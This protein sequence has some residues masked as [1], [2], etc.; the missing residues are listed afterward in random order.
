MPSETAHLHT[1]Q[2]H[3]QQ[4]QLQLPSLNFTTALSQSALSPSLRPCGP[5]SLLKVECLVRARIPTTDPSRGQCHL[6]SYINNH[7]ALE[8]LA[9]VYGDIHSKTLNRI[10]V[11]GETDLDRAARG[12]LPLE[13]AEALGF[14]HGRANEN[15]NGNGN[16]GVVH[17]QPRNANAHSALLLALGDPHAAAHAHHANGHAPNRPA[18]ATGLASSNPAA[19]LPVLLLPNGHSTP[20]PPSPLAAAATAIG[21]PS[22][23]AESA[24]LVRI[25]SSCFTGETLGSARCDCA[26]QLQESLRMIA[27]EGRGVVVYLQQEGRGIG[28][29]DKLRAYNLQDLGADTVT[30]NTLLHHPPDARQYTVAAAILAD[31]GSDPVRLLTNNPDKIAQL[32]RDGVRVAGR[33]PM[34][35]LSWKERRKSSGT[36]GRV[37]EVDGYLITKVRKMNHLLDLPWEAESRTATATTTTA[38]TATMAATMATTMATTTTATM[39]TTM[40]TATT[41]TTGGAEHNA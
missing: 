5:S 23:S 13:R 27:S 26:E 28:L 29:R 40:A 2:H 8:H 31:L 30:A 35:P 34:V 9:I 33:V 32:T 7:D 38:T 37:D 14:L 19:A 39:A 21:T 17:A 41:A 12:A 18:S 1:H 24:P 20:P 3:H 4:L 6:L 11:R 22:E 16:G 25:H 10:L 15:G 36:E